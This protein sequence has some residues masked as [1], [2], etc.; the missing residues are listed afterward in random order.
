MGKEEKRD[1]QKQLMRLMVGEEASWRVPG[2]NEQTCGG[3]EGRG[4][5]APTGKWQPEKPVTL[6]ERKYT[7]PGTGGF[8]QSEGGEKREKC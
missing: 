5:A 7:M 3:R 6:R 8:G 2:G 1:E 4:M